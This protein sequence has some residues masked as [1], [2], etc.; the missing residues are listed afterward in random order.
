MAILRGFPP[1]NTISPSV[2]IAEKDLSYIASTPSTHR[3]ALVGFASKG[4]I[5]TPT[6]VTSVRQ[7]HTI[8]G[9]PHP[10]VSDPFLIYAAE[11]YLNVSNQLYVVRVAEDNAVSDE[12]AETAYV[13]IPSAGSV[14]EIVSKVEENYVFANDGFFKWRLNGTLASKTLV[15]PA[16][17]YTANELATVLN[18][19]LDTV[20]DGIIF[21]ASNDGTDNYISVKT[22]W[23]Y[24][25]DASLELVSVKDSIYGGASSITG[26]GTGMTQASAVASNVK[27]GSG[28]NETFDFTGL[29]GLTMQLIVDG[30]GVASIDGIVQVLDLSEFDNTS[31]VTLTSIVTSLN[32]QKIPDEGGTG[33]LPGGWTAES[34]NISGLDYLSIRTDSYGRN[35]RLR[36]KSNGT[37]ALEVFAID[38]STKSGVSPVKSSAVD[39]DGNPAATDADVGG[40]VV[41]LDN[42][43]MSQIT[44][45]VYADSTGIEGNRTQVKVINNTEENNFSLQVY[46]NGVQVESWGSLTKDPASRFYVESY[47]SQVSD[48]IRVSDMTDVDSPPL[49]S[50]TYSPLNGVYS[51]SGG[52]DGI[53]S[54]PERQDELLIGNDIGYTGI[55]SLSEPEQ[56]DIDLI[57]V[58]GHGSTDVVEALINLCQNVRTDCMAIIDP[59]FGLTVK[60]IVQ[61]QNG[62]H[63]LN[64]NRFDSDFAALYWP[65]LKIRD[66]FNKLDV[67][68][69]PSGSVL[70]TIANSDNISAPWF[71]PAGTT[72]GVVS[73]V[74]DVYDRPTL[75]ERDQ[76][77]GNRN[78]V[79]PIIQF[80]DTQGFLIFGQKTL[81]RRPTALDRVNVRRMMLYVEKRI[82]VASRNLL[83]EPNDEVFRN[84]FISVAGGI[85]QEVQVGRGITDF[86]IK[87]DA[88][89]NTPDVIDRN[90][91]RARIGIQPT[92]AAEFIF[93]EFSIH[94]TGSFSENADTL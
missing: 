58:P 71:A 25:P 19:Q 16:D 75:E 66:T 24:G 68:V 35:A 1:S 28:A 49:D 7:L 79:N 86:V 20:V 72:R 89:L 62:V 32:D 77:Y 73:N 43:N 83:F 21:F 55:Y 39:I 48:Y 56:V 46:N 87:A 82:K 80:V 9:Y 63:P 47:I 5:N 50:L 27:Y 6:L 45:R 40:I 22:V 31:A 38:T 57:A 44:F 69:P 76:M 12:I 18:D 52:S 54:D 13:D 65:W 42:T 94:R 90:E 92:R 61:W 93:I 8:F 29:S 33:E 85:L 23:A 14:V 26:L 15:V 78:C 59:P 2:R 88:E 30:S 60:E 70:A 41:G 74:L 51:L 3:G 67:W 34:V 4:P 91:F 84:R 11:Q 64:S 81:Q 53:P 36:V 37:A 17:T 10:D